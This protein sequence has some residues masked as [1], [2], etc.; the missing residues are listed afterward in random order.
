MARST[1]VALDNAMLSKRRQPAYQFWVYDLWST[2]N[3][4]T[5]TTI[6]D[7]VKGNPLPALV[8]PLEF[9]A[10]TEKIEIKETA[11]EYAGDGVAASSAQVVILDPKLEWDP[12]NGSTP[13]WLRQGNVVRII[14]GDEQVSTS[15]WETTFTGFIVGQP[16]F[17]RTRGT[18]DDKP[19]SEITL[20]C[21]D[22][23]H[24]HIHQEITSQD[25]AESITYLTM[26]QDIASNE[27][28]IG[29]SEI[30]WPSF[31]TKVTQFSHNQI[32]LENPMVALA[33]IMFVDGYMPRFL[34][35]GKL[36]AT[37]GIISKGA[38]RVYTDD[39]LVVDMVRPIVVDNAVNEVTVTGLDPELSKEVGQRQELASAGITSGYFAKES[40]IDVQWSD[41]GTQQAEN[42]EMIVLQ[43]VNGGLVP[44]GSESYTEKTEADGL[45]TGG[46]I[47]VDAGFHPALITTLAVVYISESFIP[48]DVVT[49]PLVGSGVTIPYGRLF[50]AA[51]MSAASLVMAGVGVGKYSIIG[52][53]VEMVF[54]EIPGMARVE[55]TGDTERHGLT[56]QNH[57]VNSLA[58]ANAA[59]LRTLKRLRAKVN[60]RTFTMIHDLKLEPDDIF[61]TASDARYMIQEITR[62]LMRGGD[63]LATVQAFEVTA[64]VRP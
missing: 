6:N 25:F 55:L 17:H 60:Q 57:L 43:S 5:P 10:Y 29:L 7:I 15:N 4:A 11:G 47:S 35:D 24:Q 26:L 12:V 27:M 3:D 38:A 51:T 58:D 52:D 61:Q 46:A 40:R 41:D 30:D 37:S 53:P 16:G 2:R 50:Q 54:R 45:T 8:G 63:G 9:S 48:D 33:K 42:T 34:G 13:R 28:G 39:R 44:V 56:I 22:R 59:A 49:L 64:G 23:L 20:N 36:G 18:L 21:V 1:S 19:R 14:E 32:V 31:G 62:T